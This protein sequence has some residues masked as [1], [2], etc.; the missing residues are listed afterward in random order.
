M[1]T[2]V[3]VRR[4]PEYD[5]D[6]VYN[7]ISDI[8]KICSG[9][10]VRNK[11][12][13]LKPNILTDCDPSKPVCTHPVVVEAMIRF[14]KDNGAKVYVGDSP[15][16]H[17]RGF[18][19]LKSGIYQICNKTGAEWVDF[20]VKPSERQL[21]R[22]GKIKIASALNEADI[23]ISLPKLKNHELVYFTGAVKNTLGLVPGFSKA[24]QHAFHHD[25]LS[26][27]SFLV[28][29]SESVTPDFFLM[30][31]II[32]ME[33]PGPGQGMPVRTEVLLGSSNPA[34]IDIIAS[35]IAGYDPLDITTTAISLKRGR[36]LKNPDEIIIDGPDI[37][38]LIRNDFRRIPISSN[39]NISFRFLKNRIRP[40]KKLE[41]RPVFIHDK[42]TGC[43][44]C[45]KICPANAIDMHAERKNYV[46]LTDSRCIR[47][48][49]CSEVCPDNAVEIKRKLFGE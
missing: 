12:V 21:G 39:E 43:K 17:I 36:W 37:K 35:T 9:P 5:P 44:A 40:L 41:R 15:A 42:C 34:A 45:I 28:D 48:Y 2:I 29:L 33:G 20:T 27:S 47:C 25:R 22:G 14:L 26:F 18:R 11:K 46:V 13:L 23:V 3:A 4:C 16:V 7:L 24:A 10:D 19:P 31:G 49:C 1:N 8:Y 32:G 6:N 38:T 30:D